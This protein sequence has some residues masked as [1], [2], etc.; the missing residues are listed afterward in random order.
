MIIE[1][2]AIISKCMAY[3]E[4][5]WHL[6]ESDLLLDQVDSWEFTIT[7]HWLQGGPRK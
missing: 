5:L 4:N 1:D 6:A 7:D 3:F 2:R